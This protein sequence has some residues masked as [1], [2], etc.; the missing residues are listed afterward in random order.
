LCQPPVL[1]PKRLL[2]AQ[3][4]SLRVGKQGMHPGCWHSRPYSNLGGIPFL[5]SA[6]IKDLGLSSFQNAELKRCHIKI[7]LKRKYEFLPLAFHR[8][9]ATGRILASLD[10]CCSA[11]E[12]CTC[13][14]RIMDPHGLE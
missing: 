9:L 10:R 7:P 11:S 13:W 14:K 4:S 6:S 3:F 12:Y 5:D 1:K 8:I 2:A